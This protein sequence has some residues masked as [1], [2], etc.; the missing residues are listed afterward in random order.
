MNKYCSNCK[1]ELQPGINFCPECGEKIMQD[2]PPQQ[3][4]ETNN[5]PYKSKKYTNIGIVLRVFGV[6]SAIICLAAGLQMTTL[7]SV[8]GN[9]VAEFYYHSVGVFVIGLAIFIGPFLWGFGCLIDNK[10]LK[11]I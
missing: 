1:A 3:R 11:K 8:S 5:L 9:S 7:E 4:V 6:L 10:I 2:A